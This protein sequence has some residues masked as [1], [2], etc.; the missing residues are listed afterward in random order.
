M[1]SF[2]AAPSK[3]LSIDPTPFVTQKAAVKLVILQQL[4]MNHVSDQ[5]FSTNSL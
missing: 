1:W 5:S 4:R 2:P 3:I